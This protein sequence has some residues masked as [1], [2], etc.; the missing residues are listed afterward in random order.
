VQQL[1]TGSNVQVLAPEQASYVAVS[2]TPDGNYIMFVRSDKSTTNFRY[3]YQM[4]VLGGTPKQLVRDVDS[5]PSF[6]PDGKELA[7]NR[8]VVD[9]ATNN[10]IIA[11]ADGSN[12]RVLVRLKT[13]AP[14]AAQVAWSPDGRTLATVSAES[15]ESFR[16]V[17]RA[18]SVQT[19]AAR[20]LHV[21]TFPAQA[22]AWSPDGKGI[23][24]V[25]VDQT[26]ARG[27]IW[28]VS[29]PGGEVTR[30]TNDLTNYD[31]CC[32]EITRDGNAL[33]AL[34]ST[35]LSDLW[36]ANADGSAPVPITSGEAQ[37]NGL[38]WVGNQIAAGTPEFQWSRFS[39]D[40]SGKTPLLAD[41]DPH[42]LVSV[43][44]DGKHIIYMSFREEG[45]DVSRADADGSNPVKLAQLT[46]VTGV[47]CAADSRYAVYASR[48]AAWRVPIDGGEPQKLNFPG[49]LAG[50]SRDGKLALNGKQELVNGI[51]STK[52]LVVPAEGGASLYTFG[53]PY[54]MRSAQFTPDGKAIAFL[55][56][57]NHAGNI[58]EQPLAGGDPVQLTKF[59]NEEMFAF[60]WSR[61][62][63]K[64]ALSRGQRKTDVVM[65]S[66]L[67]H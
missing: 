32:L 12:E 66:N 2:F 25:G 28:S 17:L 23:L 63:K 31:L 65:M 4:P 41:R 20:E 52:F 37:G 27:Q 56:T 30:I 42:P 53:V 57:R 43:C 58:W 21:F 6:S 46:Q 51:V 10:L 13:F 29:Y 35:T 34:T 45:I 14:G 47:T 11:K 3:L 55:L 33:V 19:G 62:G 7:F 67:Y 9:A 64:L 24:V 15:R 1:A 59:T 48:D 49:N 60:A 8:G 18:V 38:D 61:D 36:L 5:A 16:F 39:V 40:G 50:F 26:L 44:P 22:L 54:G